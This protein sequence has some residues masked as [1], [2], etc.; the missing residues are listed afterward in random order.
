[1]A[2]GLYEELR[3][4][5]TRRRIVKST[6]A[7]PGDLFEVIASEPVTISNPNF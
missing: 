5:R 4:K 1:M 6:T 3:R 2:F 7:V